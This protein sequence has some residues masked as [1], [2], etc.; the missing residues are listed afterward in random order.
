MV[1]FTKTPPRGI[2]IPRLIMAA[3][4][5][6]HFMVFRAFDV[7]VQSCEVS[8]DGG[9]TVVDDPVDGQHHGY[10]IGMMA[11]AAGE[12]LWCETFGQRLPGYCRDGRSYWDDRQEFKRY[13]RKNRAARGLSERKA[14]RL[15]RDILRSDSKRF[16]KLTEQLARDGALQIGS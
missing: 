6:G 13:Q 14:Q 10:L 1:W 15:A 8:E 9:L 16:R 12:R 11:G 4:E 3:H 7:S 2:E 5:I